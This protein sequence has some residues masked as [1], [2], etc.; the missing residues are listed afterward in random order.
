M[1][2]P[3]LS[4][5]LFK[6]KDDMPDDEDATHSRKY[7]FD[8]PPTCESPCSHAPCSALMDVNEMFK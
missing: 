5:K 8:F 1:V 2:E 7:K 3:M 6:K 4:G